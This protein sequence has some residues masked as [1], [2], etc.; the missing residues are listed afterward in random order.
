M[1]RVAI[2]LE[3]IEDEAA[4]VITAISSTKVRFAGLPLDEILALTLASATKPPEADATIAHEICSDGARYVGGQ[5]Y[6]LQGR[7]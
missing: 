2:L 3:L 7:G 5:M 1:Q 6:S 4:E